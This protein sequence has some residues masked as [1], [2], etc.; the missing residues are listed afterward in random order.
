MVT[1]RLATTADAVKIAQ[2]H[3]RSWQENYRGSYSDQFLDHEVHGDRAAVWEKRLTTPA[4]N[5]FTVLAEEDGKLLGFVCAFLDADPVYGTLIDNLHVVAEAK[6]KGIGK[7]LIRKVA[8]KSLENNPISKVYLWV[9][10]ANA[11]A[12]EFYIRFGAEHTETTLGDEIGDKV[13]SVC[14]MVWETP[15]NLITS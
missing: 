1:Y 13:V 2:L 9:L 4:A 10:E 12:F 15:A 8:A 7:E 5:Q 14:R 6:G 3:A 11:P